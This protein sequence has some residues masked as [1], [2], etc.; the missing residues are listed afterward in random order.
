MLFVKVVHRF[1]LCDGKILSFITK[2]PSFSRCPLCFCPPSMLNKYEEWQ[3]HKEFNLKEAALLVGFS[4]LHLRMR[5]FSH[6]VNLSCK[7][8]IDKSKHQA[9]GA[10]ADIAKNRKKILQ[11]RFRDKFNLRVDEPCSNGGNSTTGNVTRIA[12]QNPS[13]LAEITELDP[14]LVNN[15]SLLLSALSSKFS[16]NHEEFGK[17]CEETKSIYKNHY[18][19]IPMNVSLHKLLDHGVSII[20][21][22]ILPPSYFCEEAAEA[23]NKLYRN[24]RLQ[25]ARKTSRTDNLSDVIKRA[26]LTSDPYISS[27]SLA[28]NLK[29]KKKLS[30]LSLDLQKL[31]IIDIEQNNEDSGFSQ[32]N[33]EERSENNEE[34]EE[35][36]QR[37]EEM[38]ADEDLTT[39]YDDDPD[40]AYEELFE[41]ME[42]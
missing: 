13:L 22:S 36:E 24:D 18:D 7:L 15:L 33:I 4:L 32:G 21:N 19:N 25:H 5:I 28:T 1:T 31:L 20:M 12:F 14:T 8:H 41:V 16:I 37:D 17:L 34:E 26:C 2:T 6:L 11:Q 40:Y 23:K 10:D 27:K 29:K 9:R 38:E 35:E 42:D 3:V 39:W 30:P